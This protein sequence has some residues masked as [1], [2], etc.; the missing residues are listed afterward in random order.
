MSDKVFEFRIAERNFL[1]QRF[2]GKHFPQCQAP[3][4]RHTGFRDF[5]NSTACQVVGRLVEKPGGVSGSLRETAM[6]IDRPMTERSH[7]KQYLRELID[8]WRR[9]RHRPKSYILVHKGY[10]RTCILASFP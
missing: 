4:Q 3:M 6:F 10:R 7:A 2:A 1:N 9:Y 5:G 8:G